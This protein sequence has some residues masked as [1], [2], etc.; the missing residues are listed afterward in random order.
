MKELIIGLLGGGVIT[1]LV[2]LL[3]SAR[4]NSRQRHANAPGAEVE[5]LES[6]INLLRANLEAEFARHE[7]EKRVL[8]DE[9]AALRARIAE[10]DKKVESLTAERAMILAGTAR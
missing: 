8:A 5:A 3:L 4:P 1:R 2:E 9:I 7:Q 6:T 10:L